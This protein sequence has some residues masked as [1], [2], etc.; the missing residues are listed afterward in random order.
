MGMLGTAA[1]QMAES[2]EVLGST[3]GCSSSNVGDGFMCLETSNTF[4]MKLQ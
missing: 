1:R 3:Q 4:R 2:C